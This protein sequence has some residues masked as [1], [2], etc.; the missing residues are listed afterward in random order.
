[1][2]GFLASQTPPMPPVV[3][4][5]FVSH[6][7]DFE[8]VLLWRALCDVRS[9]FY[10]DVGA[11]P[12]AQSAT[13]GFSAQGWRGIN[14]SAQLG[15]LRGL[16]RERPRDVNLRKD[17]GDRACDRADDALPAI[18]LADV[19][20]L[21]VPDGQDVH[22]LRLDAPGNERTLLEEHD[23]RRWRPWLVVVKQ[24]SETRETQDWGQVLRS[25]SYLPAYIHGVHHFWVDAGRPGL[26]AA[27]DGPP[28]LTDQFVPAACESVQAASA[29][30][31]DALAE[32]R[33]RLSSIDDGRMEIWRR[34]EISETSAVL[35]RQRERASAMRAHAEAL[36]A[37][38]SLAALR[39]QLAGAEHRLHGMT[40]SASWRLTAPL[41]AV[42]S[43]LPAAVLR[44]IRR[45]GKAAWWALTPWRIPARL[46]ARRSARAAALSASF[47]VDSGREG[48]KSAQDLLA[49][50]GLSDPHRQVAAKHG[51]FHGLWEPLTPDQIDDPWAAARWCLDLLS[52]RPDL[53][54]RF[55]RPL[56][57]G[58]QGAFA[59]WL[60]EEGGKELSLSSAALL[61]IATAFGQN[62]GARPRRIFLFEDVLRDR[63]PHGLLPAGRAELLQWM[64]SA[65]R[66][67]FGLR[68][69]E[70]AWLLRVAAEQPALEL[71]RA[72]QFTPAW[73]ALHPEGLSD[74]GRAAF[75]GWY[76][77]TYGD[78]GDWLDVSSRHQAEP[79]S[80]QIR[81]VFHARAAWRSAHPAALDG[82]PQ[83]KEFI[84][85]LPSLLG[86]AEQVV[87][88][89][90]LAATGRDELVRE[91]AG[92]GVNLIGHFAHPSGLRVSIRALAKG[93]RSQGLQ[94]S[95]R[96]VRTDVSDEEDRLRYAGMEDFDVT[97]IHTQPTPYFSRAYEL[98]G[99]HARQPRPYRIAYWYWE[100][101]AIPD[102]WLETIGDIDEV[103]TATE[104][105]AR[106]LRE[107]LPLPVRTIFPGVEL[108]PY[109]RKERSDF[110]LPDDHF[111]FLFVFHMNS[112]MER[113]NPLGLIDAFKAAFRAED[114][115][116]LVIKTMFGE[117]QP[118]HMKA[119]RDA[120]AGCNVVILNEVYD[121]ETLH[122][123]MEAC[124]AY[125]SLH[126]SEGLGLTM[127][128]AMLMAKPV[129]ATRYSG[130]VDFMDDD[131]SLLVPCEMVTLG[132]DIDLY[133][134]RLCWAEP[135]LSR[136]AEFMRELFDDR[137]WAKALGE[138]A[139]ADARSRLSV[140]AAGRKAA[141]RLA[142][143][144]EALREKSTDTATAIG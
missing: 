98:C 32:A 89:G 97:I 56:A 141:C 127:A 21:H 91:L 113:K 62:P 88:D 137:D 68:P 3:P 48:P 128:E 72:Y 22:F 103:W 41:R 135:S 125:V 117:H 133:D 10:L 18:Q 100:F 5:F 122:A 80:R 81:Q 63:L 17:F 69:E 94:L 102:S 27:F 129:I 120:A 54:D 93:L 86:P 70:I 9:G 7:P 53:R 104:F 42:V 55:E 105:I 4:P 107:K 84:E 28:R 65:G 116:T 19:C 37:R 60:Q 131:N 40:V 50:L 121:T 73:Q 29:A 78:E 74:F 44:H 8:D 144:R 67:K 90:L 24:P 71:V 33:R 139:Q 58:P 30:Q 82:A 130:N 143:I 57:H 1:M 13:E 96:D 36:A 138:R 26:L 85:A 124:D 23:W 87:L 39:A 64:L 142:E 114:R 115:A 35:A 136:A 109:A 46:Q 79:A 95:L 118:S 15:V 11:Q 34:I 2:V 77:R 108:E 119:L 66:T 140:E 47:A 59:R 52:E 76:R 126:R 45:A 43:A 111:V 134:A 132:R 92:P 49:A 12:R 20:R 101:D 112:V 106:G 6:A 25:A 61:Q 31:R 51:A 83:A 16:V 14:V 110:G 99:L 123:L 75:V 38:E